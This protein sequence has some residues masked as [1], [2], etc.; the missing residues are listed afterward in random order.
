MT[1]P[2]WDWLPDGALEHPKVRSQFGEVIDAWS[3]RWFSGRQ[4]QLFEV[5]NPARATIDPWRV[6]APGV[7][8][9]CTSHDVVALI[10][11]ALDADVALL[12]LSDPDQQL[13]DLFATTI[14]QDLADTM[15][16]R[17]P[18]DRR[19]L[20]LEDSHP[21][22][23]IDVLIADERG[24]T[25]AT[26]SLPKGLANRLRLD[27]LPNPKPSLKAFASFEKA[28]GSAPIKVEAALGSSR[29]TLAD[30]RCLVP[31]DVLVLDRRLED[32][33]ILTEATTGSAIAH[34]RFTD[35]R[36][37]SLSLLS[38]DALSTS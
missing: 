30:A 38:S 29:I 4:F 22:G 10:S 14:L 7:G 28:L 23:L 36:P 31:G 2:A 18:A 13:L 6:T 35:T 1:A 9:C 24:A 21:S 37:P 26:V 19:G 25:V 33:V 15:S 8:V 17:L 5:S 32:P 27:S 20:E 3:A 16:V 11:A 34:A 12:E